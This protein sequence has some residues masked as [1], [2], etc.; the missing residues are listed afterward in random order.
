MSFKVGEKVVYPNHGVGVI[1]QIT[2]NSLNGRPEKFYLIRIFSNGLKVSIPC[3]NA[4]CVG[5]RRIIKTNQV[6][7]V[8]SRLQNGQIDSARD[9]KMR[10]KQNSEKMRTGLLEDVAEVFKSLLALNSQKVLSFREKKML[11]RCRQL[12]VAELAIVRNVHEA[13]IE[14]AVEK[15][16]R[17]SGLH[18]P[19]N[20]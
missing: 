5:L 17:K 20:N 14:Q 4:D 19:D 15:A 1:E 13:T 8:L 18:L 3:A 6:P 7:G 11:E 16:L 2:N 9:W 10:F 12:L